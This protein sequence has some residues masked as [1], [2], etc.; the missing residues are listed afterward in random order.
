MDLP[1]GFSVIAP[2][3]AVHVV[4]D[5]CHARF[6]YPYSHEPMEAWA[7]EHVCPVDGANDEA[8]AAT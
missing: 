4:C 7:A 6:G 5:R 1:S 8:E 2:G 3:A